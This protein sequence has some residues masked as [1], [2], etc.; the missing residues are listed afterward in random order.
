MS[1]TVKKENID[2]YMKIME[3]EATGDYLYAQMLPAGQQVIYAQVGLTPLAI[4]NIVLAFTKELILLIELD[5]VGHFIAR[6]TSLALKDIESLEFKKKWMQSSLII[7]TAK[8]RDIVLKIPN[9]LANMAWQKPNL[10]KLIANSW[11]V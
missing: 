7:K 11:S 3:L 5:P 6:H 1:I 9:E 8:Y 2:E 4:K 10:E